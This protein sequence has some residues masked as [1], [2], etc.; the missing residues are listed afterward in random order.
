MATTTTNND[1]IQ[2][3]IHHVVQLNEEGSSFLVNGKANDAL[4]KYKEALG[5]LKDKLKEEEGKLYGPMRVMDGNNVMDGVFHI[6]TVPLLPRPAAHETFIYRNAVRYHQ[7]GLTAG[8]EASNMKLLSAIVIFNMALYY[9][10]SDLDKGTT[11]LQTTCLQ[12]YDMC[13]DLLERLPQHGLEC[14]VLRAI[15]FNNMAHVAYERGD[16]SECRTLL[17]HLMYYISL[18]ETKVFFE[19]TDVQ[20]F[21][22]NCMMMHPP[23]GA[24]A[25]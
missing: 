17:D 16:Y 7:A 11:A 24:K 1:G 20:G 22:L 15:C 5:I 18:E 8:S 2:S 14:S 13:L 12:L 3:H 19:E 25:A 23:T 9:H 10:I 6:D 4:Q 21:I